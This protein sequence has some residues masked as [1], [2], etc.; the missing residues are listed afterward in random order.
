MAYLT[1]FHPPGPQSSL[2]SPAAAPRET[3]LEAPA[4]T[5]SS[6]FSDSQHKIDRNVLKC[7]ILH[8]DI[9][10]THLGSMVYLIL[11]DDGPF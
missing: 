3:S 2:R 8:L 7:V 4:N 10:D 5:K 1:V 11:L 9:K 6:N